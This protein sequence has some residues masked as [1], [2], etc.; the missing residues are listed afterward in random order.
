MKPNRKN[1]AA[2]IF[3]LLFCA[4]KILH[5][6]PVIESLLNRVLSSNSEY[7]MATAV[8]VGISI[9]MAIMLL[10]GKRGRVTAIGPMILTCMLICRFLLHGSLES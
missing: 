2:G 4:M 8:F 1:K 5:S 7:L 9:F 3:L 10:K 6:L